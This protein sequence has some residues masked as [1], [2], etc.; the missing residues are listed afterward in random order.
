[1]TRRLQF[2]FA[3]YCGTVAFVREKIRHPSLRWKPTSQPT[4]APAAH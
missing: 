4:S 1:M 3:M 2:S